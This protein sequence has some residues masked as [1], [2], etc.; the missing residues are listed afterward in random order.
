MLKITQ[1]QLIRVS[2]FSS[3][4]RGTFKV[5]WEDGV[6]EEFPF[7][8]T[9]GLKLNEYVWKNLVLNKV[10]V[11][12]HFVEDPNN[13]KY[14]MVETRHFVEANQLVKIQPREKLWSL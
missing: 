8:F 5:T 9:E 12:V 3:S 4:I 13:P 10:N 14:K 6:S 1:V 2:V 11:K 7:T